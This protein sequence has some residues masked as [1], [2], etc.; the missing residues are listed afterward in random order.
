MYFLILFLSTIFLEITLKLSVYGAIEVVNLVQTC[1]FTAFVCIILS[2]VISFFNKFIKKVLMYIIIVLTTVFFAVQLCMIDI[3]KSFFSFNILG[4]AGQVLDFYSEMINVVLDNIFVILIMFIPL[5]VIVLLDKFKKIKRINNINKFIYIG[6][7]IFIFALFN[8]TLFIDKDSTYSSYNLFYNLDEINLSVKKLGVTTSFYLDIVKFTFDFSEEVVL[9]SGDIPGNKEE[10]SLDVEDAIVYEFNNLNIEFNYGVSDNVDTLNDYFSNTSGTQQNEYTSMFEGK[11]LI[12]I[13]AETFNGIVVDEKR[14]PTL[15]KLV[16]EGF[17]F[18]NFYS[19]TIYS[20]IGGE[21][22]L[23]TGLYP[24]SGFVSTFKSGDN[25][26]PFGLASVF[27]KLGYDTFA[28]H[29]NSYTF[30]NRNVY[31]ASL[32]FN[33]F[34]AC[35]N[36]LELLMDC[37]WLASDTD[38]FNVT[39]DDYSESD[40]FLVFYATVSGHGDYYYEGEFSSMYLDLVDDSLSEGIR[41]YLAAQIE[42]DRALESLMENLE[43]AG[44]LDDTVIVLAGDH[45]PYYLS[46]DEINEASDYEKDAVIEVDRSNLIIYN[47]SMESV[48]VEKVGST[49]DVLPTVYN[50]FGIEYDSRLIIGNDILSTTPGL[51]IFSDRSWV[52]D[53]GYYFASSDDFILKENSSVSESYVDEMNSVVSTKIS[54]SSLILST[55]YYKYYED[56]FN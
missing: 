32:G 2:F 41:S 23:L 16:N 34:L 31:L 17:N 28:Y 11:N 18:E 6:F 39:F 30:Q 9:S 42:L 24:S 33:N 43:E 44:I 20:T 15:Y 25:T 3:F 26:F 47:S 38:M 21:F 29:D 7:A 5:I 22:Q 55:N 40:N 37:N 36:G 45:H 35:Y 56:Y 50:L 53:Y 54:V 46:I 49:L 13:M 48:S 4:A 19:P 51:A 52:S 10:E 27:E 14:T 1:F 8:V 12:Y